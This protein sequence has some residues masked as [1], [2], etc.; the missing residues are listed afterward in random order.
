MIR[1]HGADGTCPVTVTEM[2]PDAAGS[3]LPDG[4]GRRYTCELRIAVVDRLRG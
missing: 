4:A 2:L 1:Q 3:W